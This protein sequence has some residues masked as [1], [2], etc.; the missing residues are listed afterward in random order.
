MLGLHRQDSMQCAFS[1]CAPSCHRLTQGVLLHRLH[2]LISCYCTKP[3]LLHARVARDML[4]WSQAVHGHCS[5]LLFGCIGQLEPTSLAEVGAFARNEDEGQL[6]MGAL[7]NRAAFRSALL[8]GL[9]QQLAELFPMLAGPRGA[10][11][12]SGRGGRAVWHGLL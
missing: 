6:M 1:A 12:R 11:R 5:P 8:L 2:P 9:L 3:W 7:C 4:A 10:R